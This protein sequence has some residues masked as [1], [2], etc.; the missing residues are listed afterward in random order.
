M[1]AQTSW[2]KFRTEHCYYEDKIIIWHYTDEHNKVA[3]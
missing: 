1:T 2:W 3:C